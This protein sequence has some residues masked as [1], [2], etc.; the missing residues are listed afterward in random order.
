MRD[1]LPWNVLALRGSIFRVTFWMSSFARNHLGIGPKISID[2][3]GQ[4]YGQL[5]C[6]SS[7]S[8][9]IFSLCMAYHHPKFVGL[10]LLVDAPL[11]NVPNKRWSE[12]ENELRETASAI[13]F[14]EIHVIGNQ[15]IEPSGFHI[16]QRDSAHSDFDTKATCSDTRPSPGPTHMVF[17]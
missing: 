6:F 9:P 11:R 8:D 16:K 3:S 2:S 10:D 13:P 12:I 17:R 1:P 5:D 15:D 7:S 14:R 4:F